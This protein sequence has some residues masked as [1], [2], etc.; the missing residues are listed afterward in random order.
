MMCVIV[1]LL[2]SSS[3]S[4]GLVVG[5]VATA[6]TTSDIATSSA[7][8]GVDYTITTS[9]KGLVRRKLRGTRPPRKSDVVDNRQR[10]DPSSQHHMESRRQLTL[11]VCERYGLNYPLPSVKDTCGGQLPGSLSVPMM[12]WMA[13]VYFRS[14]TTGGTRADTDLDCWEFVGRVNSSVKKLAAFSRQSV[15]IELLCDTDLMDLVLADS[16][17]NP[18]TARKYFTDVGKML[19]ALTLVTDDAHEFMD[20][21]LKQRLSA[22]HAAV[23]RLTRSSRADAHRKEVADSR[24]IRKRVFTLKQVQLM[25]EC[26]T[27]A[28]SVQQL[29]LWSVGDMT[30]EVN[31][32]TT[33][34]AGPSSAAAG[35]SRVVGRGRGRGQARVSPQ[36]PKKQ[37]Q[38]DVNSTAAGPSSAAAGPSRVVGRGRGRGQ[39]RVSPQQPK[40]QQQ[41][42]Q[43]QQQPCRW[44]HTLWNFGPDHLRAK[45]CTVQAFVATALLLRSGQR[46][47]LVELICADHLTADCS[48]SRRGVDAVMVMLGVS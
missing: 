46:R 4:A 48:H 30:T 11:A 20:E 45:V 15:S 1:L 17:W 28:A 16:S 32:S 42:Q 18:H 34:A 29:K 43:Q 35:P 6:V 12:K 21:A 44:F 38:H 9:A 19:R 36:Q 23:V 5:A 2:S 8:G 41:Q 33:T 13:L 37:Q 7:S 27:L 3:E 25:Q 47:Q 14:R 40:K 39:A 10:V 26:D 24:H 22:S 31:V